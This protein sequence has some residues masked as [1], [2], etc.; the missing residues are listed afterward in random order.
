M[1]L[2]GLT[3]ALLFIL[4]PIQTPWDVEDIVHDHE[5]LLDDIGLD[6]ADPSSSI[7]R[8]MGFIRNMGQMETDGVELYLS[9]PGGAI[10]FLDSEIRQSIYE[11]SGYESVS[12]LENIPE[13]VPT[14]I[15]REGVCVSITF[16]D[17]NTVTPV[18]RSRIEGDHNYFIG[19]DS[20]QWRRN[21][22][23][24]A[25]VVYENLYDGID[26]RYR[27]LDG[28]V[29]YEFIVHPFIDPDQIRVRVR[30]SDG[31]HLSPEGDLIIRTSVGEMIDADLLTFLQE[32]PSNEIGSSFELFGGD[33]Y[34]FRV[35][36][37]HA[38]ST[39]VIDPEIYSSYLGGEDYDECYGIA[40]DQEHKIYIT[41]ITVSTDFPTTPGS[42]NSTGSSTY[43]AFVSKFDP[44]NWSLV[45]STYLGGSSSSE[46]LDIAVDSE[47]Q[48]HVTG[49]TYSADFPT[50][51]GTF[52]V[53]GGTIFLTK[54]A[55]DGADLVYSTVLGGNGYD[56][57]G[58]IALDEEG[59]AIIGG[60]SS[61]D[62]FPIVPGSYV[63]TDDWDSLNIFITKFNQYGS[64]LVFSSMFGGNRN[65]YLGDIFI[66]PSGEIYVTGLTRSSDFPTSEGAYQTVKYSSGYDGFVGVLNSNCSQLEHMT[67]FGGDSTDY[68]TNL[69]LGSNG[70][71]I[72]TGYTYS[73]DYPTTDGAF[74]ESFQGGYTDG[75]LTVMN[76]DFS[77]IEYSSY[78]G[79]ND[80]DNP[81]DIGVSSGG[82]VFLTGSTESLD[83]PL[84]TDGFPAP[85]P[86]DS[87]N[88]FLM[89][90]DPSMTSL[91]YS[92]YLGGTRSDWIYD[93]AIMDGEAILLAGST[94]SND[95]YVSDDAF[96]NESAGGMDC[97]IVALDLDTVPPIASAGVDIV[98]SPFEKTRF[99]G[100]D[101]WDNYGVV[102][103]T[104]TFED[105]GAVLIRYGEVTNFTFK[106]PGI[107]NVTLTVRDA[108]DHSV[109][110]TISVVVVGRFPDAEISLGEG[111]SFG[112]QMFTDSPDSI[113]WS[114][115]V[116][117]RSTVIDK[118]LEPY[119]SYVPSEPGLYL[120]GLN[121]TDRMSNSVDQELYLRVLPS[122][123]SLANAGK[124]VTIDQH[125][126]VH[127][128]NTDGSVG[129]VYWNWTFD[130]YGEEIRFLVSTASFTFHRAGTFEVFLHIIDKR[131]AD[132]RD[133]MTVTVRDTT[134]PT[135][136][137]GP[138]LIID[139]HSIAYF[140]ASESYDNVG[141]VN[142]S[143]VFILADEKIILR[144]PFATFVF[145]D[146][147]VYPVYLFIIDA[148][149]LDAEGSFNITVQDITRPVARL[150]N[151]ATIG[152]Y[153]TFFFDGTNSSDNVEIVN[154]T[155]SFSYRNEVIE[156]YGPF[157]NF[158]F[159]DVGQIQMH[160]TVLD[161]VGHLDS[162]TMWI[163][164][165]DT[166]SPM[167]HGG[168]D[169]EI[170]QG[171]RV[172]FNGFNS[173]DNSG[174]VSWIW[175]FTEDGTNIVLNGPLPE[176]VF[177]HPGT[178]RVTLIVTDEAGNRDLD[179]MLVTVKSKTEADNGTLWL[180]IGISLIV[181]CVIAIAMWFFS[182]RKSHFQS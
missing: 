21:V 179:T 38:S 138:D 145:D 104:W 101:S 43:G 25:I 163:T 150:G 137:L 5:W 39:L 130:Y 131:G 111:T 169:I 32:E 54:L 97:M 65:Q 77:D 161:A 66:S 122:S 78:I 84:T 170:H 20:S 69:V 156:L 24:F 6:D 102:N 83:L 158:R 64:A 149:G 114:W 147:G 70:Q 47:G 164:V 153:E 11:T 60:Y 180:L 167:A 99:D 1:W 45:Y 16:E 141:I 134:P 154:Y 50:T 177:K 26:L 159:V 59:R 27:L 119:P 92:T 80:T 2:R 14:T 120:I 12:G 129:I 74:F 29:K 109:S 73:Q 19:N 100:G 176:Y 42:F 174:I 142:W 63:G 143:F 96:Q 127:F 61:S 41:G 87:G 124:N 148:A 17:S 123:G 52:S 181:I 30:G 182:H 155:W 94:F 76:D 125:E 33:L 79:G 95:T 86:D 128:N 71:I 46:A 139:Q 168:M 34:G 136:V 89:R 72:V 22:P 116:M 146:A 23:R 133:T 58:V 103:W 4:S 7:P 18:G 82:D 51:P 160:L 49:N 171:D 108:T 28:R 40:Y 75:F 56:Q 117:D 53:P 36:D 48:A 98:C 13:L 112:H 85:S 144:E 91:V 15:D 151:D 152:Q 62:N 115:K 126:T 162:T 172:F 110:D 175:N 44:L 140:N 121:V 90:L 106:G 31:L 118:F 132:W 81:M 67:L 166:T 3:I 57:A 35:A 157:P 135:V 93:M 113:R 55:D 178:Y 8:T 173:S 68:P 37:Y 165:I 9:F 88:A 105:R 107:H 10:S